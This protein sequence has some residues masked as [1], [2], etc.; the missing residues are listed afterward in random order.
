MNERAMAVI[1]SGDAH[2]PMEFSETVSLPITVAE[3]KQQ[4]DTYQELTK[5]LLTEDD[6]QSGGDRK[7]KKKS[8][9]R[10]YGR[11]FNITD[12]ITYEH[13]ERDAGGY[14]IWA[15]V[16][17]MATAPNGRTAEGDHEC[18]L[19]ERCCPTAY[20]DYCRK[21]G[22]SSHTCC[23]PGCSGKTHW[24]HPGDIP[25][26]A[27]TRAK[28]RAISDLIGAGEVSAEEV[29]DSRGDSATGESSGEERGPATPQCPV[30][31]IALK[32][33]RSPGTWY[34][35]RKAKAG[36]PQNDRGYC[37]QTAVTPDEVQRP[38]DAEMTPAP[39]SVRPQVPGPTDEVDQISVFNAQLI[40]A[41]R[42]HGFNNFDTL[43]A[44]LESHDVVAPGGTYK[45]GLVYDY[46]IR[47]QGWTVE[48]F[49]QR[50]ADH[51]SG[52]VDGETVPQN[53]LN[54]TSESG[55][56]SFA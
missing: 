45:M 47:A 42:A 41:L 9:W 24:S 15:R 46:C 53:G 13:V 22:W 27:T 2:P 54:E 37:S 49:A 35:S 10:K 20:G 11:A 5:A 43:R 28:N 6:Y 12:K 8:A 40:A 55:S 7:F 18:H 16:R 23:P 25:A 17:V 26:T 33:G 21:E 29:D 44:Y 30:H 38:P 48:Q 39:P 51:A 31:R 56:A 14:P 52:I 36:E 34:C 32:P 3:A 1:N 19:S 4:W 50:I